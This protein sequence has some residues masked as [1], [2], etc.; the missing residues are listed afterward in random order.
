MTKIICCKCLDE[1]YLYSIIIHKG[2]SYCKECFTE[3]MKK[4]VN[5]NGQTNSKLAKRN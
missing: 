5:K 4:E 1:K 3:I 2:S